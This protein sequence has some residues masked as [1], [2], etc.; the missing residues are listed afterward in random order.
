MEDEIICRYGVPKY[1]LID[2][3]S[4]LMKEFVEIC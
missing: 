4:E 3:G 2:N 1:V